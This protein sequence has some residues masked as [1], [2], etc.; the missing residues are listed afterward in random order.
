MGEVFKEVKE[1]FERFKFD[2]IYVDK[3]YPVNANSPQAFFELGE[4]NAFTGLLLNEGQAT[5]DVILLK[6]SHQGVTPIPGEGTGIKLSA[7]QILKFYNVPLAEIIIQYDP[8]NTQGVSSNVKL[9]GTIHPLFET[10]SQISIENFQP[11]ENYLIYAGYGTTLPE[12]YVL[13]ANG[14]LVISILNTSTG[15]IGQI[16]L[17]IGSTTMTFNLQTGTNKIP[18]IAGTQITNLTLTSP[19]AILIYEEVIE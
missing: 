3:E 5:L 9:K 8:S 6:H 17:T 15:N 13:P 2:V 19:S 4:R 14:Y 1:K 11:N 16:T 7:G 10:P 18:V 12:S